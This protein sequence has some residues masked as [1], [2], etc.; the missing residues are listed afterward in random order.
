MALTESQQDNVKQGG[1]TASS[2][3]FSASNGSAASSSAPK[4]CMDDLLGLNLAGP[5]V[6]PAQS[7][8]PWGLPAAQAAAAASRHI[9]GSQVVD[10]MSVP[11]VG[12]VGGAGPTGTV[13]TPRGAVGGA[14]SGVDPWAPAPPVAVDP[15]APQP[16]SSLP[17]AA[18][19]LDPWA[20]N[21]S[22]G[23]VSKGELDEFDLISRQRAA[24]M[25]P[26]MIA[27]LGGTNGSASQSP[28]FDM[29]GLGGALP[30]NSSAVAG[31]D[32]RMRKTPESFL[33]A[34]S[35]L[36]NLDALVTAK[37]A[38]PSA[39]PF[40]TGMPA[41]TSLL[42]PCPAPQQNPFQALNKAPTMNELRGGPTGAVFEGFAAGAPTRTTPTPG[43]V[44]PFLWAK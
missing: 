38:A 1:A 9:P 20:V 28:A 23:G 44:N 34:N 14:V 25:S 39:N 15:W 10:A 37:P 19:V 8:D 18:P 29:S 12:A 31:Q 42:N 35:N 26:S 4:S 16:A 32:S 3:A 13:A 27:Q 2:G 17:S 43:S 7:A 24:N 11:L 30:K 33:G 22:S 5:T 36:V 40:G 6:A 21:G 41:A